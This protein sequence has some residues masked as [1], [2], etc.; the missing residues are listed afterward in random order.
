MTIDRDNAR[1][2]I[3]EA[4]RGTAGYS[5]SELRFLAKSL[6]SALEAALTPPQID[7]DAIRDAIANESARIGLNLSSIGIDRLTD[8]VLSA[9]PVEGDPLADLRERLDEMNAG[10]RIE[11]SDYTALHDLAHG[12]VEGEVE[13]EFGVDYGGD[14]S[15]PTLCGSEEHARHK[16]SAEH[17][18]KVVRRVAARKIPAG[19][20][21]VAP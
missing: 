3:A 17:G 1:A 21:E 9:V 16:A 15:P 8:V 13:Y 2:L 14:D 18:D 20:W 12:P 4:Q 7:R 11:Y 19:E 6:A 10:G 5:E